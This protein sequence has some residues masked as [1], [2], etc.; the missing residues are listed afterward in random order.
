MSTVLQPGIPVRI[1]HDTWQALVDY[2]KRETGRGVVPG[3]VHHA[4]NTSTMYLSPDIV[5]RLKSISPDMDVAVR[6]S[7]GLKS[8]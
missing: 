6:K 8:N 1:T 2:H 7:I 4:D 3:T 5:A